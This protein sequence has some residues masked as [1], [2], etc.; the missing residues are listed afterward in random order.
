MI[1]NTTIEIDSSTSNSNNAVQI[2]YI[3]W[4]SC[5][6]ICILFGI[7]GNLFHIL[8]ISN[9]TYRKEPASLYFTAIAICELIFL[10]GL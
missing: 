7:P 1:N 10:L 6:L 2:S 5:G 8:M 4:R 3:V 9:K